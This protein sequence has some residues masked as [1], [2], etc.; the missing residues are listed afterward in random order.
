M[1]INNILQDFGFKLFY[2]FNY[3]LILITCIK[4]SE[5]VYFYASKFDAFISIFEEDVL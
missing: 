4:L 5:M 2:K 1:L 3:L